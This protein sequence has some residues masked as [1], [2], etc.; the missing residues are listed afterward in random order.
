MCK[1]EKTGHKRN[2]RCWK[3]GLRVKKK[4]RGN[5]IEGKSLTKV[6][7]KRSPKEE[8]KKKTDEKK[9]LTGSKKDWGTVCPTESRQSET[10]NQK[11]RKGGEGT[12]RERDANLDDMVARDP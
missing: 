2:S 6:T 7:R 8:I 9:K 3:K 12:R 11:N 10:E 4:G 5:L 1:K